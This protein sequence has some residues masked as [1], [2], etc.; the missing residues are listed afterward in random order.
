[1]NLRTL[2]PSDWV[3]LAGGG[4]LAVTGLLSTTFPYAFAVALTI[5]LYAIFALGLNVVVGYTGL[6][7]LGYASFVAI[8]AFVVSIGLVLTLQEAREFPDLPLTKVV[9]TAKQMALP[10]VPGEE[11][12]VS[13]RPDT[14]YDVIAGASAVLAARQ[15]GQKTIAAR[16]EGGLA[17]PV[18]QKA[19]RGV[20]VFQKVPGGYFLLLVLAGAAGAVA[21]LVRGFPTLRLTGDY[22]AIVTLGFSEIVYLVTLN[23]EWLTGGAF[24]I[25]LAQQY[26]PD[27]LG[28]PLY[29]DTWQYYFIV[30]GV[31]ALT[32][33]ALHRMRASRVGRTWSAIKADE[34]AA[35]ASGIDVDE[36]KMLAFAASGFIG[37][38]GGGL[39]AIKLSTVPAKQ[40][41]IWLSII[42]VAS[43]VLGGMGSIRGAIVG[44]AI[45]MG[46]GEV[47]RVASDAS[48]MSRA[49]LP[50]LPQEARFL[51]YG[52]ILVVLM[53][54]R[55]QGLL[56]P[57][58]EGPTP[59]DAELAAMRQ[60]PSPLFA[61]AGA[62]APRPV[63]EAAPAPP[64]I[65]N[66][67][68]ARATGP[69]PEGPEATKQDETRRPS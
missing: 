48:V 9:L 18:G 31:L 27:V 47:L 43:L 15:A 42:V 22:Y 67:G 55:P 57:R 32:A 56:P 13:E 12:V 20:Q 23:E 4:A 6:L 69:G 19:A 16:H 68:D 33:V 52:V 38:V 64:T 24:G 61:L 45:L 10:P 28:A 7:D 1:M 41:D 29:D 11:V 53:R 44:A 21:G 59:T 50:T 65:G 46:L 39:W 5:M 36:A 30:L 37:A 60:A 58:R 54:F 14:R 3:V 63:T 49:H 62:S 51:V 2:R 66:A 25:R 35:R 40:F 8:G 17:L 26:R 34:T